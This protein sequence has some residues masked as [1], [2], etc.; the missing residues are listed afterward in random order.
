MQ[1]TCSSRLHS[2]SGVGGT[3][4]PANHF[5]SRC[6]DAIPLSE[7]ELGVRELHAFTPSHN[8][9][10]DTHIYSLHKGP[11]FYLTRKLYAYVIN[12]KD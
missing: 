3:A 9:C 12:I 2:E 11:V 5:L 4:G 8:S 7:T 6:S 10:M 1:C